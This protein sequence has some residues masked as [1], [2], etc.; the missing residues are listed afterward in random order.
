MLSGPSIHPDGG[1]KIFKLV[2]Y[3]LVGVNGLDVGDQPDNSFN[4]NW[5]VAFDAGTVFLA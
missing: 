2:N 3:I 4:K 1:Y 5:T